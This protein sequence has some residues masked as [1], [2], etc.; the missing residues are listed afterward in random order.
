M[1]NCSCYQASRCFASPIIIASKQWIDFSSRNRLRERKS[2]IELGQALEHLAFDARGSLATG[3]DQVARPLLAEKLEVATS[4][5]SETERPLAVY[6]A[7]CGGSCIGR[8][9]G[10]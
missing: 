3:A 9:R 2:I 6:P 8:D 5:S 10:P 7:R 4:A 1:H